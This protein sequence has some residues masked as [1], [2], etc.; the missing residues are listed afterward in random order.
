MLGDRGFDRELLAVARRP[1]STAWPPIRREVVPVCANRS[2]C[3]RCRA[4]EA[5]RD[6][7]R[8]SAAPITCSRVHPNV[9]SAAA[10]NM[11]MRCASS[12][13]MIGSIADSARSP[14]RACALCHPRWA[15]WRTR[16]CR[17]SA[18]IASRPGEPG[19]HFR[20][21]DER[22][23]PR[24]IGHRD[25]EQHRSR[26]PAPRGWARRGGAA[27]RGSCDASCETKCR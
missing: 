2:M 1:V 22:C 21:D 5:L 16:I 8:R 12:M 20:R 15:A 19:R 14:A 26:R 6:E 9:A 18:T 23:R 7:H 3:S 4:A 25:H 11:T 13:A 17:Y 10:L 24:G 27:C